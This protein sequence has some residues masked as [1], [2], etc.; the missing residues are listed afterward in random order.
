M[1]VNRISKLKKQFSGGKKDEMHVM[2]GFAKMIYPRYQTKIIFKELYFFSRLKMFIWK[3]L[4]KGLKFFSV[5]FFSY[6]K[7]H[8]SIQG[9]VYVF[10]Y[11]CMCAVLTNF[12]FWLSYFSK[13]DN[14]VYS[15][16][17]LWG[18]KN[19]ILVNMHT[20]WQ[21]TLFSE[22]CSLHWRPATDF[23]IVW[24]PEE[25]VIM[26]KWYK[27]HFHLFEI[28]FLTLQRLRIPP[29]SAKV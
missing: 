15:M 18:Y 19:D 21:T 27:T 25:N 20:S 4:L 16:E 6:W 26:E 22:I 8:I 9:C 5:F 12:N 13:L 2:L 28:H 1:K 23:P 14:S 11:V 7:L 24:L 29:S 3:G 17:L 10:V